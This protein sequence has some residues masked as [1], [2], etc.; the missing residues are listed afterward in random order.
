[1][2]SLKREGFLLQYAMSFLLIFSANGPV[3]VF[4]KVWCCR[5]EE[6]FDVHVE[7]C[8]SVWL[9]RE[10]A[11]SQPGHIPFFDY[12]MRY[13]AGTIRNSMRKNLWKSV[14]LGYPPAVY[15]TNA[16]ESLDAVI[17]REVNYKETEWSRFNDE[18]K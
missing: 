5:D 11:Y 17:K 12:F 2:R 15:T 16:S 8:R 3:F 9:E 1:M 14:G 6:D 7:S 13:F 10:C 18:L 4:S